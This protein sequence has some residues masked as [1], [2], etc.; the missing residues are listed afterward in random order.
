MKHLLCLL[1]AATFAL[2]AL[3]G[4]FP[5]GSPHFQTSFSAAQAEAK[6]TGKPMI[7]VFSASWC[8][9]CQQM[10]K[11]VYPSA[12]VTP[13]HD[14]F[15]WAYLDTDNKDNAA[16]AEKHKV[17]GIPHIA[18]LSADG[19]SVDEQVGSVPAK[20]FAA[21]LTKV[22]AKAGAKKAA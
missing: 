6:K 11:E 21:K 22:L 16:L 17:S 7:V 9:P 2:P 4:D 19:K 3:A 14:K 20:A 18:F 12:D 10:K 1:T 5:K 13:F 15:V 8:G